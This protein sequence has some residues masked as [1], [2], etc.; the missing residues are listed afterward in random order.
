MA[1][2]FYFLSWH[3][4]QQTEEN[5]QKSWDIWQ[6]DLI[7]SRCLPNKSLGYYSHTDPFIK[8]RQWAET[9]DIKYFLFFFFIYLFFFYLFLSSPQDN[10]TTSL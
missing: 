4:T 9:A 6:P 1:F 10:V 8:N 2:I 5:H 3:S 7:L